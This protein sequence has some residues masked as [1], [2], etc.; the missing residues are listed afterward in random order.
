LDGLVFQ[1]IELVFIGMVLKKEEVDAG[2]FYFSQD[3]NNAIFGRLDFLW[4]W[5][6]FGFSWNLNFH[7]INF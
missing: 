1:D 7:R 3:W 5:I 2:A 6:G 4:I